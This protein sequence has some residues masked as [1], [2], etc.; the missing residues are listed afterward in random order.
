MVQSSES[1]LKCVEICHTDQFVYVEDRVKYCVE[2]CPLTGDKR[3][4]RT[5][6]GVRVCMDGCQ[7]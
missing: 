1:P 7:K 6:K 5:E 2:N 3:Y 4:F